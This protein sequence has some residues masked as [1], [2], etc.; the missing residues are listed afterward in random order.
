MQAGSLYNI[1]AYI[2][3]VIEVS[4]CCIASGCI[5]AFQWY[6]KPAGL[7]GIVENQ[8]I[9]DCGAMEG[10]WGVEEA[11]LLSTGARAGTLYE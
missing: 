11:S 9:R 5:A 6:G 2:F 1:Y 10:V 4:A 7:V 3:H 8:T